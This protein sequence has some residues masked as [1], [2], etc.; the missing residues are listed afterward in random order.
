MWFK[1][2]TL[3][4]LREPFTLSA[5]QL[6]EKLVQA[7]FRPCL[8]QQMLSDGW[9]APLGRK[10]AQLVHVTDGCLLLCLQIEEKILPAVVIKDS[11]NE[12][13]F[14]LEEKEMRKVGRREKE[15]LRDEII[16]DLLPRAFTRRRKTYGYIDP[17]SGWLVIDNAGSKGVE[18]FTET[19]R[20]TLGTLPIAPPAL[21]STPAVIMTSWL[22][23]GLL[24]SDIELADECDMRDGDG[25]VQC[26][27]Q[28]L[29]S[30]EIRGHLQAGKQVTKLAL[31]WDN[32]FSLVLSAELTIRRLQITDVIHEQLKDVQTD[33]DEARFDAQFALMVGELRLFLPR[34]LDWFDGEAISHQE[35]QPGQPTSVRVEKPSS[36]ND[37]TELNLPWEDETTR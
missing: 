23:S 34:L 18:E 26:K 9:V 14:A 22:E 10:A 5:E 2:I 24:P 30:E 7:A 8:S 32:R 1:N 19:L 17:R 35:S 13:L 4:Q 31:S 21:Q 12:K 37:E 20:E 27:G 16:L 28:D 33:S 15:R 25:V 6:E 3:F 29:F 11:L 36:E